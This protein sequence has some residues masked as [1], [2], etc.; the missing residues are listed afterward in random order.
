M[1][2]CVRLFVMVFM[3]M[4][5]FSSVLFVFCLDGFMEIIVMVLLLKFIRK[6]CISLFIRLDLFVLLVLVMF[7]I[8]IV[9]FLIFLCSCFS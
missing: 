2:F 3:W 1:W 9:L 8:G 7:S 5:L 6:W 4:W